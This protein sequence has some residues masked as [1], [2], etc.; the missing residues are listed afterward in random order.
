[1]IPKDEVK[2]YWQERYKKQGD[3]TTGY[4]YHNRIENLQYYEDKINFIKPLLPLDIGSVYDYGCGDPPRL[5]DMFAE[6]VT[7][8]NYT[9]Y[10]IHRDTVRYKNDKRTFFTANVL[11]H[12]EDE[13]VLEVLK[14]ASTSKYII[15]YE[16]T[17]AEDEERILRPHCISRKV[18]DYE[19]LVNQA[20]DKL[21]V[22]AHQHI[23]HNNSHSLMIFV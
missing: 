3:L 11:Q 8:D 18:S 2:T 16:A 23:I 9:G 22:E 19:K 1:M 5:Q 14:F 12:N 13:T 21:I 7:Y 4:K 20:T 6:I 15:L 17:V 10:D